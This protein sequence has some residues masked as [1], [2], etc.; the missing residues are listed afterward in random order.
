[1]AKKRSNHHQT[2]THKEI[3]NIL[4][5]RFQK[6][7]FLSLSNLPHPSLFKDMEKS[8]NRIVD[9]IKKKEKIVLIGDYDVDGVVSITLIKR[10]FTQIGINLD[11]IIPSRFRDGYGLSRTIIPRI[12]NYNL[13]IT[14]DN[15][16]SAIEASQLCKRYNIE[17]IIT[18]HHILPSKELPTAYGIINPKQK[19]CNF[20]YN[21]ICGAQIAWYLIAS[22]NRTLNTSIEIKSYL[23]L[24]AIAIIA[25]MMPLQHINRAMVNSGLRVLYKSNNPPIQAFKERLN[26]DYLNADDIA[27]Q[28]APILNSAGRMSDAK[29]AVEF[30]LSSNIFDARIQL[31]RLV[32]FNEKRKKI[33]QKITEEALNLVNPEDKIIVVNGEN[34][35]E[36]VIGIVSARV[37]RVYKKPTI[38]LTKGENGDLKGSGR[39]FHVCNLFEVTNSCRGLLNKFGGHHSAIGLSLPPKNLDEFKKKLQLSYMAQNYCEKDCDPDILGEL[40]FSYINFDLI[41]IL[42]FY[43]PYGEGNNRPKFITKNVTIESV[44][45]MGKEKEHRR[46]L[47][48]HSGILQEGILFKTDKHF[49]IGQRLNLIYTITE[50]IFNNRVSIQLML[51]DI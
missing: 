11:W 18:D 32:Q 38:I 14:V 42:K 21:E 51:E 20:P 7:G 22:L 37:G 29:Y 41:D 43:E 31:E 40:N 46:L 19:D 1:M 25:D 49:K 44:Q 15:G 6:D 24:V 50:N 30:L 34:W 10:F 39:S 8:T 27:F 23:G 17:L 47:L 12:R 4:K 2:L 36:G 3:N 35:H 28:I 45:N 26:K 5:S 48:S 16:I 33:E 13:A 9:A